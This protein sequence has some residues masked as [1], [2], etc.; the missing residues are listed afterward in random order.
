M[1]GGLLGLWDG[2]QDG[3]FASD[4]ITHEHYLPNIWVLID[5]G[6][7]NLFCRR[8]FRTA[9]KP[10][11]NTV[12]SLAQLQECGVSSGNDAMIFV[13]PIVA[14]SG[15]PIPIVIWER[16]PLLAGAKYKIEDSQLAAQLGFS[17]VSTTVEY[18]YLD[19]IRYELYH[20][21]LNKAFSFDWMQDYVNENGGELSDEEA[22]VVKDILSY[23]VIFFNI[24]G[25]NWGEF[26]EYL[27]NKKN[28]LENLD[29]ESDSSRP[30]KYV[31]S[32]D[33][34]KDV[35]PFRNMGKEASVPDSRLLQC[36][37]LPERPSKNQHPVY[38]KIKNTA[39]I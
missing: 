37:R 2:V 39:T 24:E 22:E 33:P 14:V 13:A 28:E 23:S 5:A 10:L 35:L 11:E 25:G 32:F 6:V 31:T 18:I 3:E 17:G 9:A 1:S 21:L 8:H 38:L 12:P 27:E 29:Q 16:N 19:S 20:G 15:E 30:S 26:N 36:T 4:H 7:R 34:V